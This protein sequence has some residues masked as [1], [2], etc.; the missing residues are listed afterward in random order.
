MLY[1]NLQNIDNNENINHINISLPNGLLSLIL[2]N[3]IYYML[4][5]Y[6]CAKLLTGII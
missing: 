2:M 1:I 5:F 4:S 3:T 6:T